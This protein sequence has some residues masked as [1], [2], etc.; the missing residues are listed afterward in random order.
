MISINFP[1][2][3]GRAEPPSSMMV[4]GPLLPLNVT[5]FDIFFSPYYQY[6]LDHC[7]LGST[8]IFH[9]EK[10][11]SHSLYWLEDLL[12]QSVN[13]WLPLQL[14]TYPSVERLRL[15]LPRMKAS[16]Q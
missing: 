11:Y 6:L 7:F 1:N 12:F 10:Q 15:L 2:M 3:E 13:F 14:L 8:V 4:T 9:P 16:T 5:P